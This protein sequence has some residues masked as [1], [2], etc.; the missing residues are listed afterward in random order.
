MT[1]KIKVRA[2]LADPNSELREDLTKRV[3]A[4]TDA[5]RDGILDILNQCDDLTNVRVDVK[6]KP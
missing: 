4:F 5:M 6:I 1:L 3:E 2:N